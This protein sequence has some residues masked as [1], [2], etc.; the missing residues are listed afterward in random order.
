MAKKSLIDG[1]ELLPEEVEQIQSNEEALIELQFADIQDTSARIRL[2]RKNKLNRFAFLQNY[3]LEQWD[4]EA[5]KD[6][7]GGGHYMVMVFGGTDKKL[8]KR[9]QFYI[10]ETL[11]PRIDKEVL[12]AGAKVSGDNGQS[13]IDLVKAI[14]EKSD[15][16]G[17]ALVALMQESSKQNM[18]MML[19]MMTG[20]MQMVSSMNQNNHPPKEDNFDK[21]LKMKMLFD[22]SNDK[23]LTMFKEGMN[24]A[25]NTEKPALWERLLENLAP[26]VPAIVGAMS[27]QGGVKIATANPPQPEN[28]MRLKVIMIADRLTKSAE[29]NQPVIDVADYLFEEFEKMQMTDTILT[30]IEKPTWF[31]ELVA[32]SPQQ[33]KDLMVKH[34]VYLQNV[35]DELLSTPEDNSDKDTPP[36]NGAD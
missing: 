23:M 5:V 13:V 15:S 17:N 10:D 8:K 26:A 3:L 33:G 28:D 6:E 34:K 19:T 24:L 16:G 11:K 32:M 14:T 20:M 21:L 1:E 22:G 31:D 18:Q 30:F 29:Q 9:I 12:S 4:L 25:N 36:L 27:N 2:L 7:H 35:R